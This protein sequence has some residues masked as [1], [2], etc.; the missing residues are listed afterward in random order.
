M[1]AERN[2]LTHID[3]NFDSYPQVIKEIAVSLNLTAITLTTHRWLSWVHLK[4]VG[5]V[6]FKIMLTLAVIESQ[7]HAPYGGPHGTLFL[8]AKTVQ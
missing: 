7:C 2:R 5:I 4:L 6:R 1:A 3:D 8:G